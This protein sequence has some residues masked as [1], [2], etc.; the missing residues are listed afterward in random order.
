MLPFLTLAVLVY[1]GAGAEADP[2]TARAGLIE[3]LPARTRVVEHAVDAAIAAR[4]EGWRSVDELGFLAAG[5]AAL[6]AGHKARERVELEEAARH[7]EQAEAA[8]TKGLLYAGVASLAAEAALEHGVTLGELGRADEARLAFRR[9][10]ALWPGAQLTEK[11]AR[12]DVVRSFREVQKQHVPAAARV[13]M[14]PDGVADRL[15][16]L[17]RA[18]EARAFAALADAVGADAVLVAVAGNDGQHLLIARIQATCA[19]DPVE[20]ALK[21]R[22]RT[23]EA[24]AEVLDASCTTGASALSLD[25]PRLSPAPAV[26]TPRIVTRAA[27]RKKLRVWPIALAG[28]LGVGAAILGVTIGFVA[29]DARYAVKVDGASF[30]IR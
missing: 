21:D 16:A 29:S 27:P 13:A 2:A 7:L 1:S 30:G 3:A 12:P 18:P 22:G 8:F 20:V 28:A 24:V 14:P 17:R 23:R 26:V 11:T 19:T 4:L 25:D 15:E 9:A 5:R 6:V 10:L